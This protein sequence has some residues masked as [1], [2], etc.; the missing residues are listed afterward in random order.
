[1]IQQPLLVLQG[2]LLVVRPVSQQQS[3]SVVNSHAELM[4]T[5]MNSAGS[6]GALAPHHHSA[7]S[8]YNKQYHRE[9]KNKKVQLCI[10]GVDDELDLVICMGLLS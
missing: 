5:Y 3:V 8:T 10:H 4:R 2:V 7:A 6:C 1:M 9:N